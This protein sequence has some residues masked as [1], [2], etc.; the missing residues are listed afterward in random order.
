MNADRTRLKLLPPLAVV[1]FFAIAIFIEVASIVQAIRQDSWGP[2]Y[3][4][5]WLPV[6]VLASYRASNTKGC[7]QLPR[8]RAEL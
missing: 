2:M 5:G 7:R 3:T 6:V 4:T 8:R 1:S